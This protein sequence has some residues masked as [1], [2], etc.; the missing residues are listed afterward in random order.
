MSDAANM[1]EAI[2]VASTVRLCTSPNPWVGAVVVAADGERFVGATSEPGGPHAEVVA[3]AAAGPAAR[4]A[5]LYSTLE[6]CSH[7]GR[8]GPCT[9]AVI[10][11]GVA[12]VVIGIPDPDEH[13]VGRGVARLRAAGITVLEGVEAEAVAEQL[14]PYVVQRSTG[15]PYVVLKLAATLDGRT[16]A[17]DGSSQWITGAAARADG[18]RL[19]AESDA[20]VVGA[21]TVRA[22]DPSLT[23]RDY[24]PAGVRPRRGLDP[25]RIVLGSIP[26]GARVLPAESHH[27][28][29]ADLLDGLG[30]DGVLQLLVEGGARVAGDF[31]RAGLVDEY[32]LYVAPAFFGGDD[33]QPLFSGHGAPTMGDL[34]R[35]SFVSVERMGEDVRLILRGRTD[36]TR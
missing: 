17:P 33:A 5:T 19:R 8:T 32:V 18:H 2:E 3:L 7:Q 30:R 13:V 16:A 6:P 27:G 15:R 34:S 29:L 9:E 11:A 24:D 22:D 25:R 10:A 28:P 4:G 1:R 14:R 36:P 26:P 21:A 23:V 12:R 20:I 31:H 35:L